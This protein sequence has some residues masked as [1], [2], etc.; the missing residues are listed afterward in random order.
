MK[1]QER[2]LSRTARRVLRSLYK[3]YQESS[4]P[5]TIYFKV[6]TI[7][8]ALHLPWERVEDAKRQ[9]AKY[10]FVGYPPSDIERDREDQIITITTKG[11]EA[12]ERLIGRKWTVV[13]W[14][15][16]KAITIIISSLI[17]TAAAAWLLANHGDVLKLH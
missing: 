11:I 16:G 10:R 7:Q 13:R 3:T 14:F 12:A 17:A 5:G 1:N 8:Q 6:T 9:L 4:N 2:H 15:F